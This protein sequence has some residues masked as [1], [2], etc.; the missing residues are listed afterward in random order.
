MKVLPTMGSAY[1]GSLRGITASHNKGGLYFR[2]RTVPTNPNSGYQSNVRMAFGGLS[3]IWSSMLTQAQRDGWDNYAQNVSWVDSLGQTIQLSGINHYVRSNTPRG[4]LDMVF[5]T[6]IGRIDDAP[7]LNELGV[8]PQL[9]FVSISNA[10][11]PPNVISFAATISNNGDYSDGTDY[12]LFYLSGPQ[13]PGIR[14]FNG[15]YILAA[16]DTDFAVASMTAPL[17]NSTPTALEYSDR[18]GQPAV[19]MRIFGYARALMADGRLSSR[20]YF[21]AGLVPVAS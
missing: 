21:D 17:F 16:N 14:S 3:Q 13:N 1:S 7:S 11:G 2:G 10:T 12:V 18:F 9:T 8:T 19:G 4:Q 5:G 15:P 6:G 20:A